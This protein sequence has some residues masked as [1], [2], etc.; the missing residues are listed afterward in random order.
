[1]STKSKQSGGALKKPTGK[2]VKKIRLE[3]NLSQAA[4]A[5]IIGRSW[6]QWWNYENDKQQ[7][8]AELFEFYKMK[9]QKGAVSVG[10]TAAIL[11]FMFCIICAVSSSDYDD[12]AAQQY[13]YCEMVKGGFWPDYE[14]TFSRDCN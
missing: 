1:M 2:Q 12:Q 9:T 3:A 4:S 11:F 7:M 6:R 5:K 10:M 8:P 13:E 14:G